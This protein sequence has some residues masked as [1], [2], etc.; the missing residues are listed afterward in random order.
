M[1]NTCPDCNKRESVAGN[2]CPLCGCNLCPKCYEKAG[3]RHRVAEWGWNS[4][5]Y[6]AQQ[7]D[8]KS[9]YI[10]KKCGKKGNKIAII[11]ILILIAI[12]GGI[13]SYFDLDIPL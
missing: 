12:G 9:V 7:R 4:Q 11:L 1:S 5:A 3:N 8:P 6:P 13:I 10:C 2:D